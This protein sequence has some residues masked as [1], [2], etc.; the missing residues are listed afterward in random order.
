MASSSSPSSTPTQLSGTPTPDPVLN[1]TVAYF[2]A[3]YFRILLDIKRVYMNQ[4]AQVDPFSPEYDDVV[5]MILALQS[6][7]LSWHED[8]YHRIMRGAYERAGLI[9]PGP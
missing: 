8:C 6:E 5:L 1:A 2:N 9:Y 4:L 7:H 3:A